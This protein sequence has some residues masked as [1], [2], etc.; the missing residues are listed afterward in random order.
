MLWQVAAGST[1]FTATA[2]NLA[3]LYRTRLLAEV[4]GLSA[5][6]LSLLLSV[7]PWSQSP[8]SGLDAGGF[9]TLVSWLHGMTRW[10]EGQGWTVSELYLM[11]TT[12][13]STVLTPE[14]GN[15]VATLRGPSARR[16]WIR[17]RWW[18]SW[19][20]RLRR[21]ASWASRGRRRVSCAGL[22]G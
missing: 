3:L 16:T 12:Q 1:G 9:A 19:R 11:V 13:Y 14:I 17:T 10:L 21:A 2:E 22:T 7:S 15:L 8:L 4:H 20:R 5:T 18:R 6:E